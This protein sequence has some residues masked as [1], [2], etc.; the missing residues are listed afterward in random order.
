MAMEIRTT[1]LVIGNTVVRAAPGKVGGYWFKNTSGTIAT[2]TFYDA[3]T[4]AGTKIL[5]TVSV[6]ATTG[7]T[8]LVVFPFPIQFTVG[9]SVAVAGSTLVVSLLLVD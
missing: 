2:V 1:S 5:T 3:V 8:G 7:D 4:A 6:P 9:V